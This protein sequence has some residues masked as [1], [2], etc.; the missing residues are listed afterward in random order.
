MITITPSALTKLHELNQNA[1]MLRLSVVGGGCSG[2]SYKLEF[3]DKPNE[4]DIV[5]L[6]EHIFVV[7]DPKSSLFLKGME[8]DHSDGLNGVG[9]SFNNPNAKRSCGCGS[10]F[11]V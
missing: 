5:E 3:I 9:F 11:S 8:L 2:L 4:K 10:S 7:V 6:V 1:Q